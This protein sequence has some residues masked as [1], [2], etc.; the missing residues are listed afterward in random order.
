MIFVN[1]VKIVF[2]NVWKY[3]T[4]FLT[5]ILGLGFGITY[6]VLALYWMCYETSYDSFYPDL[7]NIYRIYIVEKQSGE[8][9]KGGARIVE[10]KLREQFPTVDVSVAFVSG[11]KNCRTEKMPLIQL[12]LLYTDSSIF[13]V[14]LQEVISGNNKQSLQ[15]TNNMVLSETMAVLLFDDVEEA[16]GKQLQNTISTYLPPYTTTVMVNGLLSSTNLSFNAIVFHDIQRFFSELLEEE[17]WKTFF[18]EL[19]VKF[20][21]YMDVDEIAEQL[22][23]LYQGWV[24]MLILSCVWCI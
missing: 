4:Q 17:Q 13:N 5:F 16:I 24:Q 2:H 12:H 15:I 10:K 19:Y 6:F 1:Y 21:S 9:N 20:N 3:Q 14:F 18:M 11:Q 7:S 22:C 8:V 23:D